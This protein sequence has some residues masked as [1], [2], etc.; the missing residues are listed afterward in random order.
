MLVVSN[1][2]LVDKVMDLY[3]MSRDN[4]CHF[5]SDRALGHK[6]IPVVQEVVPCK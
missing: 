1:D 2:N 3:W 4:M 5:V 6:S